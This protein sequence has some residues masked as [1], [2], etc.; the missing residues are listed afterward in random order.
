[1]K[2]MPYF[3]S[4]ICCLLFLFASGALAGHG[5]AQYGKPGYP[6]GFPNFAYVNPVAPKG[7]TLVLSPVQQTGF[8]KFNPFSLKGIPAPGLGGLLFESLITPSSDE[9]ASGYGL[10]ANDVKVATDRLSVSFHINPQARFSNGEPVLAQDVKESFETLISKLA[11]PMYRSVYADVSKVVV[12]SE[13]DVRFEFRQPNA[14]LPLIVG[15]MPVFSKTWGSQTD[16]STLGFDKLGF[17]KPVSSGPYLIEKFEPGR[18]ITY[19][20]NPDWWAKDLNVRRGMYN[21][22]R[23][24]FQ[25]YKDDMAQ[26]EAFKAGD[27]DVS[28]EFRA[29][30][31]ARGY[32]G[33]RF[34]SGELIRHEFV[35][36]NGADMQGFVMNMRRPLFQDVRVRK[37]LALAIDFEW[38]NRQLF[39]GQ[40]TRLNSFYTDTEL[41]AID[42]PGSLPG[43][44]E[45][46]LLNPL[47]GQLPPEVFKPILPP[48]ST[49]PPASLRDNLRQARE[50]LAEAGWTYR[51]GAL[52]NAKGEPFVFEM[53]DN[54]VLT[55]IDVAYERNLERLGI[56]VNQR[57]VDNALFQKRLEEF[58]FDMTHY[59]FS[60][61]Q[62][63]GNELVD[64]FTSQA[65]DVKGS[66]NLIG[67]R[68]PAIDTLVQHVVRAVTREDLVAAGR[69]L[70]RVLI[71]GYY[72]IPHYYS[73]N[74]RVA[75]KRTLAFPEKLPQHYTAQEWVLSTWWAKP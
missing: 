73:K 61:S 6:A 30:N 74:H 17:D 3:R 20:K 38:M 35:H 11:S 14:E 8:D 63:P 59:G 56:K 46:K 44:D 48:A 62:S 2:P 31:W 39:F 12:V 41:A 58:D 40:Y 32:Q 54:N 43:A 66:E 75:Y 65:A 64:R 45:L 68:S 33:P 28:F 25:I 13:R 18:S 53:L 69:A 22:E 72:V 37:A 34:R 21:F 15:T 49:A 7:G 60:A 52:R 57:D 42:T 9:V 23:I 10:L 1:M 36:H 71:S 27:F 50:L 67:L 16:G 51:D 70:D 4:L 24:V 47:R 5:I 29:K 19:R 55:R 26:L